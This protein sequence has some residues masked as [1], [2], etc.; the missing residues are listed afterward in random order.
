MNEPLLTITDL[1]Q[2]FAMGGGLLRRG[3]TV[4]AVDG[5]TLSLRRGETLGLVGES[6]CGKSTLGRTLLKLFEPTAGTIT[7]EG[8][9]I[10]HLSPKEMRS[11]RQEMQIVFQDPVESLNA[12][13]TVGQILE[14][15]FIIHGKGRS[16]ERRIWVREL[17]EKV[18]LPAVAAD[19]YPH[20]FSGGQRQ[21]IGIARAI[22]LKPKLLVCDEAVSALDVSVQS[23]ILN[24]LLTLQQ[25][26]N[27]AMIF[28][29]HDLSVVKHI[30]DRI[31]VMY[32][33]RVV[34]L[35]EAKDLYRA[36]RHPYTQ[37]LISAIPVPDPRRR[38]QRILLSGDVPSPI[39]PPPGCH[40]HQRCPRASERCR[41]EAPQLL[42]EGHQV[43]CH[44]PLPE[45][46]QV[47]VL[48][49]A[50]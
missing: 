25:E 13:H 21:R 14:E 7:F 9:D 31:A 26:M 50:I 49:R 40:F 12:R 37:A 11:L 1:K 36:P 34:E 43:A 5:I 38:S 8:R 19:R 18:G 41:S 24:L 47:I 39:A 33:G 45:P 20:E 10:T 35:A 29:A 44:H 4:Y 42:G 16:E 2:H 32:L 46:A 15:P 17:L 48:E 22:A 3:Y 30:S 6:G 23:Q 28:I 27:L